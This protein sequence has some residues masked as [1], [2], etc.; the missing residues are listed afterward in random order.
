MSEGVCYTFEAA[1]EKAIEM[2]EN[3]FRSYLRAISILKNKH[4]REVLR[5]AALDEMRHKQELEKALLNGTMEGRGQMQTRVQ[6]MNLNYMLGQQTLKPDADVRQA[7]AYAIH[8][9]KEA[10]DFYQRMIEGCAGAPMVPVFQLLLNDE[11]RHLQQLEN[12]YED[13]FLTEN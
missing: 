3:G 12:I 13:H 10:I 2:E 4:A 8:I 1:I 6:T 11:A 7:L 5:D 9:E